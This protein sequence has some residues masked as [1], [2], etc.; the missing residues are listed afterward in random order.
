MKKS[1]VLLVIV[2]MPFVGFSQDYNGNKIR[3]KTELIAD[4]KIILNRDTI[5]F[6]VG[7][8]K[9]DQI[10]T[11]YQREDGSHV[12]TNRETN[13][14]TLQY[15]RLLNNHDS[16]STLQ[17]KNYSS[18]NGKPDLTI[19]RLQTNHDSL[20]TLQEKNYSSLDGLPT[21]PNNSVQSL[22]GTTVT[23]N[24]NSGLRATLTLS[25][26]TT[27]TI[28][29]LIDGGEGLIEVTN[30]GTA[31]T[32]DIAGSTGYTTEKVMGTNAVIDATVS[33]HTTVSYWR[34]GSVLYY[35]FIYDN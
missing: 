28:T 13:L 31:Y 20:S 9:D 27:L 21:L 11:R 16:L 12:W 17:E 2:L 26:T 15:Y 14:D 6:N 19:Y 10:L 35:G 33:S 23:M 24:V 22:S 25:G 4:T 32:L 5:L 29:N 1:I 3:A 7:T 34:T 30:G 8:L 18:L